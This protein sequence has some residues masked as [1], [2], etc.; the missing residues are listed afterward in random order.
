MRYSLFT[1]QTKHQPKNRKIRVGHDT[2]FLSP[3]R[4]LFCIVKRNKILA[5]AIHVN[6][7]TYFVLKDVKIVV[8]LSENVAIAF[9]YFKKLLR[10]HSQSM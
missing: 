9:G 10:F 3:S 7:K 1:Y 4:R 6:H 2:T 5:T 8:Y